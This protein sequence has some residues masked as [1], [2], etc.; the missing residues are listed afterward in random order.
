MPD[1]RPEQV[2]DEEG[3]CDACR[4]AYRKHHEIDWAIR[5]KEFEGILDKYRNKNGDWWDC[6]IPVSGGKDSCFQAYGM[7]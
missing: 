4:S 1:S 2:F 7:K 5:R 6:V 3:V